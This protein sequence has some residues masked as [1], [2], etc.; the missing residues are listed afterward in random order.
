[1]TI[2][3]EPFPHL[4]CHPVLPYC[5]WEWGTVCHSESLAALKRGVQE[6]LFRLG[7]APKCHQTDTS[8]AA[9]HDLTS[10]KRDFNAEY[11]DI[12][13]YFRMIPRTI[14]VGEKEQNGDVEGMHRGLIRRLK[15]YLL[16]RGSNDF[17]SAVVYENWLWRMMSKTNRPRQTKLR[18]ELA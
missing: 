2:Q 15:Q 9:T 4:L 12:M 7:H 13:H 10:G 6:A 17:E 1:M 14:A 11:L 3:V 8:T 18:E 5:N 16:L